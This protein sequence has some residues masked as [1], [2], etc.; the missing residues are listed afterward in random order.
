MANKLSFTDLPPLLPKPRELLE[1]DGTS[2]L[3]GDVRLATSNVLPFMRKTMRGIFTTA[4]VRIVANKKRFV[5]H[6]NIVEDDSLELP[7]PAYAELPGFYQ[8]DMID[9]VVTIQA[10]S[11]VGAIWGTQTFAQLFRGAGPDT[12][13]PNLR[14]RD[15]AG[16]TLRGTYLATERAFGTMHLDE[17]CATMDR[18]ANL[19]LNMVMLELFGQV[20][21]ATEG[22]SQ[23]ILMLSFP[24]HPELKTEVRM[25][26]QS[27]HH[28]EIREDAPVPALAVENNF[29]ELVTYAAERGL[30]LVPVF[31]PY[32]A[33]RIFPTVLPA[34][35]GK[36]VAGEPAP[37]G[38]CL[39]GAE[40]R[41]AW[42]SL[43]TSL[44]ERF[45]PEHANWLAVQLDVVPGVADAG[46][47]TCQCPAC[48]EFTPVEGA[49][50]FIAWLVE[51]LI[52]KAVRKV[53]VLGVPATGPVAQA[54]EELM[55]R[56][57][58]NELRDKVV[59]QYVAGPQDEPVAIEAAENG[60]WLKL[61]PAAPAVT[62]GLTDEIGRALQ[63]LL[64]E[65]Q[66]TGISL[67]ATVDPMG[68]DDEQILAALG[69]ES[70]P[71]SCDLKDIAPLAAQVLFLG[72]ASEYRQASAQL[73][74]AEMEL[75]EALGQ[76]CD[77]HL[78]MKPL[79]VL[80][81]NHA[82]SDVVL[83]KL[84]AA[85]RNAAQAGEK[86][87]KIL[88][89]HD[90]TEGKQFDTLPLKSKLGEC[91]RLG[92]VAVAYAALFA[93]RDELLTGKGAAAAVK[94]ARQAVKNALPQVEDNKPRYLAPSTLHALTRLLDAL[95]QM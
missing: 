26:W 23:E 56:L 70:S 19:K 24:E 44:L 46:A 83:T 37:G 28:R 34:V 49:A 71:E 72:K 8:L 53:A 45:Y 48:R 30:T 9:N 60:H 52:A 13:V 91:G 18:T 89:D 55:R 39:H 64:C 75:A 42:E 92:G 80:K 10:P 66:V 74:A 16:P 5:I 14:I 95:E 58:A 51:I 82:A 90:A 31:S 22:E 41:E 25:K 54:A 59:L 79:D 38:C 32:Q 29:G 21:T 86:F 94:E 40:A 43:Y 61:L 57:A 15:W 62:T 63:K 65:P 27:P 36:T 85:T 68:I 35:A 7:D 93:V 17:W 67:P 76:N 81:N 73:L 6:V 69:W 33:N 78:L 11:Q 3:S 2:E 88:T 84:R 20:P 1:L 87:R 50:E 12:T 77:S 4:N 47:P